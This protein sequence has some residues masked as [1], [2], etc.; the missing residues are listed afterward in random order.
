MG[1]RAEIQDEFGNVYPPNSNAVVY[2]Y[3]NEAGETEFLN[4]LKISNLNKDTENKS[5]VG[6]VSVVG[7]E[8]NN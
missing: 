2:K 7:I 5:T 6:T 3:M 8:A 1:G 4:D